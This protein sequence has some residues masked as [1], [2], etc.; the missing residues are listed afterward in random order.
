ML[1]LTPSAISSSTATAAASVPGTL[2]IT[3]GLPT[4][5]RSRLASAIERAASR[6]TPG[7]SSNET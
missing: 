7:G 1:T 2:I 5:S 4:A 3:L 6:S